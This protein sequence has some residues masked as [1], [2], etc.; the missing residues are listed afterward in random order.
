METALCMVFIVVPLVLGIIEF[1]AMLTFR[2]ALSQAASEGA[3][4]T[5]GAPSGD[6]TSAATAAIKNVMDGQTYLS[7]NCSNGLNCD[8]SS[9]Y[10]CDGG[11]HTCVK[12]VV[13]AD[14]KNLDGAITFP[15]MSF[16]VPSKLSFTSTVEV[17]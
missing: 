8:I 7:T 11:V 9:P 16:A 3:R 12:V 4:A 6:V 1:G 17:S 14:Y 13:S 10:S 2:Q 5:V 15:G